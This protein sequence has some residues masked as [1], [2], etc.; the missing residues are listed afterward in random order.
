MKRT[1]SRLFAAA[2][3]A[4]TIVGIAAVPAQAAESRGIIFSTINGNR[5]CVDVP[6]SSTVVGKKI[7][8]WSCHNPRRTNQIFETD[9]PLYNEI[10]YVENVNSGLCLAGWANGS[11]VTQEL[12]SHPN[13]SWVVRGSPELNAGEFFLQLYGTDRCL[14]F[15]SAGTANGTPLITWTC[16][17]SR[18]NPEQIW[19]VT[20]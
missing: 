8:T 12:C 20:P 19:K 15:P 1:L 2:M 10:T 7:Q 17:Y 14:A 9:A 11:Q 3:I 18:T 4:A 16:R 6:A 5:R 13:T